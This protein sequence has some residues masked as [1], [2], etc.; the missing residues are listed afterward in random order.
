MGHTV[1][2]LSIG[3]FSNFAEV[4]AL[5]KYIKTKFARTLLGT[6]KVIQDNPQDTWSNIPMQDFMSSSD[7]DWNKSVSEPDE[8][9]YTKCVISKNDFIETNMKSM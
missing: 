3:K 2:F 5:L 8:Q 6:L 1:T 4:D 7:V 9:L